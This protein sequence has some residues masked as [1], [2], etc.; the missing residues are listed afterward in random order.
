MN[1]S[2]LKSLIKESVELELAK[3]REVPEHD[4]SKKHN[5]AMKRIFKLY[6]KNTRKF[7]PTAIAKQKT[8]IKLTR[9]T[10]LIAIVIAFLAVLAGCG[11]R[12]FI[13]QSFRGAVYSDNTE[14][15][16]IDIESGPSTIEE[17]YYLS[18]LPEEFEILDAGSSPFNVYISYKNR[19]SYQTISFNQWVKS[20]FGSIHYNTE[21]YELEE[22]EING[23]YGVCLDLS[24][25]TYSC[26]CAIWDNGDYILEISADLSKNELLDLAKSAKVYEN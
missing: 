7:R 24:D 26:S 10:A 14:L 21:N 8:H 23:H 11:I 5:R 12:Y 17:K 1:E 18:E 20:E 9:K 13:S 25:E 2:V 19:F 15:F 4:F 6:E 16:P 22:I 3:Y